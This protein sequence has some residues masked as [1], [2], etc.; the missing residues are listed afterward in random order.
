[1]FKKIIIPFLL[2]LSLIFPTQIHA[3]TPQYQTQEGIVEKIIDTGQEI[4]ATEKIDYQVLEIKLTKG[5]QKGQTITI[6]NT[7]QGESITYLQYQPYQ[8]GDKLRLTSFTPENGESLYFIEGQVKRAG[9]L[10]LALLFIIIV[11]VVGRLWGALSL[12]GLLISFLVIFKLIAPLIIK[13]TNPILAA[14]IGSTII[15]PT[16]FYISHGFNKKTHVGILAT[17]L[18]LIITGLLAIYFVD[19]AHLTGYASEEAGFLQFEQQGAINIKGLLLA[20]IIIGTLGILDDVTIGQASTIQELKKADPRI[21]S[22]KLYQKGMKV[23]QDHISS[24]V[25]TLVLVYSGSA[26]PLILLFFDSQKT[27]LDTLEFE[28]IAE[29]IVRMLVGSIGLII[30][31]PLATALA[32]YLFTKDHH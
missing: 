10:T 2:L 20:G 30:S 15:I 11:L 19:A 31:A 14:V 24:M 13:G 32:A 6:K 16:T 29:E 5:P 21:S 9:L 23:G 7:S 4:S 12:V 27:F 1:M 17:F 3:Q 26:L 22:L 25:N 28:L 18:S 8:A